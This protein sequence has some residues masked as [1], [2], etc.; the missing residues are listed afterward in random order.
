MSGVEA[1]KFIRE[2]EVGCDEATAWLNGLAARVVHLPPEERQ[3]ALDALI[4]A[5]WSNFQA[6]RK[7]KP[8][9]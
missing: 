9:P 6:T 2:F 3:L 8:K 4:C 7:H 5:E 1:D